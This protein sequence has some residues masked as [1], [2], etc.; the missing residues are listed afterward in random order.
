MSRL[1][2][3]GA[4]FLSQPDGSGTHL[5]EQAAWRA[6][7]IAPAGAWYL[8]ATPGRPLL[9]QARE[10]A[11]CTL[12]EAGVWAAQGAKGYVA[13]ADGDPRLAVDV[14]VLRSFRAEPPHPGGKLFVGWVSGPKGRA[15]VAS[16]R[17]YRA[18]AG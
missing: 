1:A 15:L 11:A 18:V 14:H 10:R 3:V 12:I 2:Q 6:A 17:G 9:V 5:A 4:P 7:R 8:R 13:L 16:H